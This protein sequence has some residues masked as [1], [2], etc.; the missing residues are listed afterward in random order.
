MFFDIFSLNQI[1]RRT[2]RHNITKVVQASYAVIGSY[3][4]Y[5]LIGIFLNNDNPV[6]C[7]LSESME[8]GFKR[9]DIL[10]IRKQDYKVGDVAVF[11]IYEGSFPIVHRVIKKI[12]DRLLTKGDNNHLDD[13]GLYKPGKKML[14]VHEMRASV[15]GYIPFFGMITIWMNRIPGFQ[16]LSMLF[17]LFKVFSSE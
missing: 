11:Q 12:G 10:L 7:V 5:K 1:T 3:M 2:F 4:I 13:V 14:E 16:L 6:S 15:F 8:P 17:T 9:G